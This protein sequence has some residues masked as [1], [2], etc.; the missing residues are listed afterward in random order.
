M[1]D[2]AASVWIAAIIF[3]A[4]V[5]VLVI[6]GS[7]NCEAA[8]NYLIFH[9]VSKHSKSKE[10]GVAY[11]EANYS[12]G[13]EHIKGKHGYTA[14]AYKDSYNT[15]A[16]AMA[17]IYMPIQGKYGAL[18][19]LYGVVQSPSYIDG[20]IIPMALPRYEYK[21]KKFAINLMFLPKFKRNGAHVIGMQLK[22]RM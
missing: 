22:M 17:G 1:S 11:N 3:G 13:F 2:N 16:K 10:N 19:V 15:I 14:F 6:F 9:S 7:R 8:E 20:K 4:L 18:G 21:M 5:I 12:I